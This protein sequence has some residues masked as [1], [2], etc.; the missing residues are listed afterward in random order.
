MKVAKL[1]W[2]ASR[3]LVIARSVEDG[4]IVAKLQPLEI[5]HARSFGEKRNLMRF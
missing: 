1:L 5:K 2:I 3:F 4:L